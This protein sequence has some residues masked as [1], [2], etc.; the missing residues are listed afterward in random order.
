MN[1]I[2]RSFVDDALPQLEKFALLPK[3]NF[4]VVA[5]DFLTNVTQQMVETVKGVV[6][7]AFTIVTNFI[8]NY[9]SPTV[10][11]WYQEIINS[12]IDMALSFLVQINHR[13]DEYLDGLFKPNGSG[14][15][16][17]QLALHGQTFGFLSDISSKINDT[18]KNFLKTIISY[19][20][21]F[22]LNLFTEQL[23]SLRMIIS[24]L[25]NRIFPNTND[26]TIPPLEILYYQK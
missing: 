21:R 17:N 6:D 13:I 25:I 12:A 15:E 22:T 3:Q 16:T 26:P 9:R 24:G 4:Q 18:L 10:N 14:T 19:L 23:E 8:L 11:V 5:T 7:T 2:K 1:R 20:D